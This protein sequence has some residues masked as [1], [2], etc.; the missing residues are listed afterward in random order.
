[1]T[2]SADDSRPPLLRVISGEPTEEELAAI[3]AAVSTRS[4]GTAR[5]T[6]TFSLWARK[7]RQV[8]PAQRPG[9]GAWRAST[10]PR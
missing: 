10:M 5:A 9:F 3:I 2:P 6:P 1:M 4:S 8:R 7:S